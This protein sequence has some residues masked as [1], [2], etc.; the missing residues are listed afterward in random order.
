MRDFNSGRF[1]FSGFNRFLVCFLVFSFIHFSGVSQISTYKENFE[2]ST[3]DLD[4][5]PWTLNGGSNN[6]KTVQGTDMGTGNATIVNDPTKP[7][8]RVMKIDK[9]VPPP[10][11]NYDVNTTREEIMYLGKAKQIPGAPAEFAPW[12]TP[13]TYR[14]RFYFTGNH[15]WDYSKN[16]PY[17]IG[18]WHHPQQVGAVPPPGTL[19]IKGNDLTFR[20]RWSSASKTTR[21][22]I[23]A[24]EYTLKTN[25]KKNT[26]YYIVVDLTWDYREGKTGLI[27]AYLK[28]GGWP[29]KNNQVLDHSGKGKGVGYKFRVTGYAQVGGYMWPW[30]HTDGADRSRAAGVKKFEFFIDDWEYTLGKHSFS[31]TSNSSPSNQSPDANAGADQTIILPKNNITLKGSAT[32]PDGNLDSYKWTQKSGPSTATLKKENTLNLE[33]S[34]LKKG[35]YVFRLTVKDT[36]GASDSDD[37]LVTVNQKSNQSPTADAGSNISITLPKDQITL[38][39]KGTDPDGTIEQYSWRQT[40]GPSNATLSGKSTADLTASNLIEGTYVFRLT[41]TDNDGATHEDGVKLIVNPA[42]NEIPIANA[43]ANKTITLPTNEIT[44]KGSGNDPDGTIEQYSWEQSSGPST[45]DLDGVNAANL[46]A[47]NLIAG[48]YVFK[49]TVTDNDGATDVDGVRIKVNPALNQAPIADAGANKTITLPTNEITIKGSGNDPDGNIDIF[50][51]KQTS[52]PSTADLNGA[53]TANLTASNL[54]AGTYV[55]KLTVTDNDGATDVD[56]I[57]VKVNETLSNNQVP[58]ANAGANKTI[59]LPTNEITIKG[60][61]NDPDGNI[62]IFSWKQS[63]GPST[64]DLSGANTA[65]LTASNL[66]V[67]TYV[68]KLTV[69]DND[70]ATDVDGVQVKVNE[71]VSNNQAPTAD[72]G[73]N[74]TITLPKS[75]VV[76]KGSGTDEDGNIAQ[77]AWSQIS[78][79]NILLFTGQATA[80]LNVKGLVEGVYEFQLKVEDDQG[81]SDTD[82]VRVTVFAA[83]PSI[84]VDITDAS[85]NASDGAIS[86]NLAGGKGP[87]QYNWST[88]AKTKNLSGVNAGDYQVTITDGNGNAVSKSFSINS[89]SVALEITADITN[90]TCS[91]NNGSIEVTASG[92][93]GP[94][95]FE[96]SPKARSSSLNQLVGGSYHLVVKDQNGCSQKF[97]FVVGIDPA[98]TVHEVSSTVVNASCAGND[99]S[100]SLAVTGTKGPYSFV[101]SHG[102]TGANL[103]TLENGKYIVT[104][105]DKHGCFMN[106]EYT[107]NQ[108]PGPAKPT[109][110]QAGD[111]LYVAQ[112]ATNY[113]WFRDS[114]A[115]TNANQRSL[116]ITEEGTYSVQIFNDK[117]CMASSDYFYAKDPP[118][119]SIIGNQTFTMQQ[120]D[121]YPNPAIEEIKVRLYLNE[122]AAT[123]ITIYDFQGRVMLT[124]DLGV[125]N[126]QI[127]ESLRVDQ[128]PSG[129]FLIRV[130]ANQEVLTRRF[131]KH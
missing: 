124:R 36:K 67:G 34:N 98:E 62:D 6:D 25:L 84:S 45:A 63:S 69:T 58:I 51:W 130:K 7:G 125:V 89:R 28:A 38:E 52:G 76:F 74:K 15:D 60:S 77:Y 107:I 108:D 19:R 73:P 95:S 64:A 59:T 10:G 17:A 115:I 119:P 35:I 86:L 30:R 48:T 4:K 90:A 22:T 1:Y 8:N 31:S 103:N 110:T 32:D 82:Q 106:A 57:Q 102:A 33:A 105:A 2:G 111:S 29:S 131:I 116:K 122:P 70:G 72:A 5:A 79:P 16:G 20:A 13:V 113:Q 55:F 3:S 120:V 96:W 39:G 21:E 126:T 66:V 94:Y 85:C 129:T 78:G 101:W 18:Q 11:E 109:I 44:I 117:S 24:R 71:T 68:F 80:D 42:V 121:I 112:Q 104:I 27:R 53:N 75:S 81:G 118:P 26:W 41:V 114:I 14:W 46:T 40:S 92:G 93:T 123:S 54:I 97:S 100:I 61:G 43:G 99:G 88:G 23:K 47:S 49:L 87:F 128:Y 83:L 127:I 91:D 56:G 12:F 50:S 37:V 65:D 9:K